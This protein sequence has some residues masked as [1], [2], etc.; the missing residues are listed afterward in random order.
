MMA[1]CDYVWDSES[2]MPDLW[3]CN[4][5]KRE[6]EGTCPYDIYDD[7]KI[8]FPEKTGRGEK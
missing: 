1:E 2:G 6:R 4:T 7:T 3:D 8:T 5:C